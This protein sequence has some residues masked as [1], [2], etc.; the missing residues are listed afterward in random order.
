MT[1]KKKAAGKKLKI[2]KETVV[3]L[4]VRGRASEVKGGMAP[5]TSGPTKVNCCVRA[6]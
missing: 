5:I 3:D 4:S 6:K 2:K 1:T